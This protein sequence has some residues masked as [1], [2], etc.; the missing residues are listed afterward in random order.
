MRGLVDQ[1]V[2]HRLH[3]FRSNYEQALLLQGK[4]KCKVS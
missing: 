3:R 1:Y 2:K 4:K